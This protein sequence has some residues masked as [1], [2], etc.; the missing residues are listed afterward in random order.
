MRIR[1]AGKVF[2][3]RRWIKSS[4]EKVKRK[5]AV[6]PPFEQRKQK[7][8]FH[9]FCYGCRFMRLRIS[10]CYK[11]SGIGRSVNFYG[12]RHICSMFKSLRYGSTQSREPISILPELQFGQFLYTTLLRII[13]SILSGDFLYIYRKE[14]SATYFERCSLLTCICVPFIIRFKL[15]Q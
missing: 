2:L 13:A 14:F 9:S 12:F 7:L 10:L 11:S 1:K 4:K 8:S 5:A 6:K 3:K 15:L